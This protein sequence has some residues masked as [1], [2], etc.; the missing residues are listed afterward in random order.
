[1][2][3]LTQKFYT[4]AHLKK[5]KSTIF[6]IGSPLYIFRPLHTLCWRK[7]RENLPTAYNRYLNSPTILGSNSKSRC[8]RAQKQTTLCGSAWSNTQFNHS[9][10]CFLSFLGGTIE[11]ARFSKQNK[12]LWK[13]ANRNRTSFHEI[14]SSAFYIYTYISLLGN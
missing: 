7:S 10:F 6:H 1:M 12:K 5:K 4:P 13:G 14:T 8:C 2:D 3:T 9:T 11:L